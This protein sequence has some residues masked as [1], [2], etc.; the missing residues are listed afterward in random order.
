MKSLLIL[1]HDASYYL[2]GS[3]VHMSLYISSISIEISSYLSIPIIDGAKS[4]TPEPISRISGIIY[5][6]LK[7]IY[8]G[9]VKKMMF[10]HRYRPFCYSYIWWSLS[11]SERG[12]CFIPYFWKSKS[13]QSMKCSA[14]P[15]AIE[16]SCSICVKVFPFLNC[17]IEK[18]IPY[19]VF[20]YGCTDS[21]SYRSS[22]T[23]EY[24]FY[25]PSHYRDFL[26]TRYFRN[27]VRCF[28]AA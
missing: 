19:H 12:V 23:L 20:P 11:I 26:Y 13:S 24:W 28:H 27:K 8:F 17:S 9:D 16:R 4:P 2:H 3:D 18:Y 25:E 14:L 22:H 5:A 1:I 7:K 6:A 21:C 10:P 15:I